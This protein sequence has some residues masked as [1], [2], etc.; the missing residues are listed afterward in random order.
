MS[1]PFV[2]LGPVPSAT[3]GD[4][5]GDDMDID[6]YT[7][8]GAMRLL[9]AVNTGKATATSTT[10]TARAADDSKVRITATTSV[11]GDR[12]AVTLDAS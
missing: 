7:L 2:P 11:D 1:I 12:T 10:F 9:L 4:I 5:T 6:G 8:E 3:A